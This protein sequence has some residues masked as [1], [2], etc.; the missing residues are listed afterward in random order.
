LGHRRAGAAHIDVTVI[1]IPTLATEKNVETDA[2]NTW[3]IANQ[4]AGLIAAESENHR[5]FHRRRRQERASP[6]VSGSTALR[7]IRI[8]AGRAPGC[9][10]RDSSTPAPTGG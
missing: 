3:S 2:G 9:S 5:R 1:A 6:V 10:C 4:I 7:P 8:G